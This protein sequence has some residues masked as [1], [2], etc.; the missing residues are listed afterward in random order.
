MNPVLR[1]ESIQSVWLTTQREILGWDLST[2]EGM[3]FPQQVTDLLAVETQIEVL[4]RNYFAIPK[5]D[6]KEEKD[7][8]KHR[9]ANVI[10]KSLPLIDCVYKTWELICSIKEDKIDERSEKLRASIEAASK[11]A[12]RLFIIISADFA[13]DEDFHTFLSTKKAVFL[14]PKEDVAKEFSVENE[15]QANEA[16][17]LIDFSK[18]PK[19]IL[20]NKDKFTS[21]LMQT[22][23]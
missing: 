20:E 2:P 23:S 12:S 10:E 8:L 1:D 4:Q 13:P 16:A 18:Y 19:E 9:I 17:R 7:A 15:Q 22:Y 6:L 5:D 14:Y 21:A 3:G 11:V